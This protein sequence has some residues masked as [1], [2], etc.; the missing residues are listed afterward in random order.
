MTEFRTLT[1]LAFLL[2]G[3]AALIFETLWFRQAGLVFGNSVSASAVVLAAFMAGLGAGNGIAARFGHRIR[4]P[5]RTFA[6][7]EIAIGVTG[8]LIVLLF[9]KTA[10]LVAP[11]IRSLF[12]DSFLLHPVRM[13]LGFLVLAL[14]A[15]AMGL[16]LPLMVQALS[17]ER[18]R[19]RA[20]YGETLGGLYGWN[21]LGGVAGAVGGHALVVQF[22][23][24]VAAVGAATLNGGVALLAL[25]LSRRFESIGSHVEPVRKSSKNG[26]TPLLFAAF[27]TGGILLALE[28]VW[29]RFLHLFVHSTSLA[30]ALMLAAVLAGIGV[31]GAASGIWLK[32]RPDADR[33]AG[34]VA[35]GCGALTL[36]LYLGFDSVLGIFDKPYLGAPTDVLLAT[37]ALAFPTALLSG[38]LFTFTGTALNRVISPP[39]RSTGLLALANTVGAGLGPACAGFIL[40]PAFGVEGS[41]FFLGCLYGIAGIALVYSS[42]PLPPAT[43]GVTIAGAILFAAATLSFPFGKMEAR[44]LPIV[45]ERYGY[46]RTARIAGIREGRTETILYLENNLGGAPTSYQLITD[47]FS[48]ASSSVFNRRYMKLFVYWPV[49]LHPAPRKALLI[50]YGVGSTAEALTD[51]RALRKIDIVDI[52]R[53][54]MEMS[55]IVHANPGSH[56]LTDPRVTVYIEDG[57]YYL[58]STDERYDLITSEPPPPKHAGVVNLYTKEYFQLIYDRLADGGINTYWLP[59]HTLRPCEAKAIIRAYCEVFADCSLW[60]GT[61]YNWNL[62]GSRNSEWPKS[63]AVFAHNGRILS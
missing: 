18:S 61:A 13:L 56:P 30:F 26:R 49:A 40:L 11:T 38:V 21:T 10:A 28:V 45:A 7:V 48:M 22:G 44:Y 54:V 59:T 37:S 14:P 52:S 2:S 57:R 34:A 1:R 46:P 8:T 5:F 6:L 63:E 16:T 60:G 31:G 3:T 23:M 9:P 50:S 58:Q 36:L 47:G 41:T 15:T 4:R 24:I 53:D 19:D 43:G 39:S 33:Y 55:Q 62:I 32:R 29:F 42:R 27:L 20:G 51:T 25:A 35:F 17:G 12:Q